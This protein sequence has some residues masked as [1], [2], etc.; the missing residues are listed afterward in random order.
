M[1]ALLPVSVCMP[2]HSHAAY[3]NDAIITAKLNQVL[4]GMVLPDKWQAA[5]NMEYNKPSQWFALGA[6]PC[7][8]AIRDTA[9][10]G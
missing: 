6:E 1:V 8:V 7:W 10:Y 9:A 4:P 2:W 3:C 5:A